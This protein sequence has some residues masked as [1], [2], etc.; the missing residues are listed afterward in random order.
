MRTGHQ[1]APGPW[2]NHP[3]RP[4]RAPGG[5]GGRRWQPFAR[6][7]AAH[8]LAHR[9]LRRRRAREPVTLLIVLGPIFRRQGRWFSGTPRIG[10][11]RRCATREPLW[12]AD[13]RRLHGMVR[14]GQWRMG[15]IFKRCA[16]ADRGRSRRWRPHIRWLTIRL[17]R[18]GHRGFPGVQVQGGVEHVGAVTTTHP[19]IGNLELVGNDL[20]H[21]SAGWTAGGETHAAII[22]GRRAAP[23]RPA[24]R[25]THGNRARETA[26]PTGRTAAQTRAAVIRIQPSSSSLTSSASQ[27]A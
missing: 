23:R 17:L 1:T 22:A 8:L 26:S 3:I 12:V 6:P 24:G 5:S 7:W 9:F 13:G 27:G 15:G 18:C 20:E 11:R 14:G 10:G 25:S 2:S 19:A 16:G 4:D 21:R